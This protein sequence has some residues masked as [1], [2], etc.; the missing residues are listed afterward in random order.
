MFSGSYSILSTPP[1]ITE[2]GLE[3]RAK[4]ASFMRRSSSSSRVLQGFV[5]VDVDIY[6]LPY[7]WPRMLLHVP[8]Y[9]CVCMLSFPLSLS[10]YTH[11]YT[12]TPLYTY[13]CMYMAPGLKSLLPR[14]FRVP[15]RAPFKGIWGHMRY[16]LGYI[17]RSV[18]QPPPSPPMV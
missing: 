6:S 9:I 5:C 17:W 2:G 8:I 10:L 4:V 15:L 1:A 7:I 3:A 11:T 16:I 13:V 18:D 14:L 12:C